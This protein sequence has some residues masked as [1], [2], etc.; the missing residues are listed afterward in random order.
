MQ[1]QDSSRLHL[2]ECAELRLNGGNAN[3]ELELGDLNSTQSL[4]KTSPHLLVAHVLHQ[5]H[6]DR[7]H[8]IGTGIRQL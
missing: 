6:T 3:F 8:E 7:T 2:I 1:I 4:R 5:G